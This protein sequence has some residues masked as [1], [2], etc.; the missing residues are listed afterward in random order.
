M[1]CSVP[2]FTSHLVPAGSHPTL[3]ISVPPNLPPSACPL[4]LHLPIPPHIIADRH[5]LQQLH[6]EGRLGA[7]STSALNGTGGGEVSF[8]A[9]G[10][11]DLELP[12]SRAGSGEVLVRLREP[13]AGRDGKGKGKGKEAEEGEVTKWEVPLHLRYLEPVAER[14]D[15]DGARRDLVNVTLEWPSLFWS[16]GPDDCQCCFLAIWD[17]R[18]HPIARL[19]FVATPLPHL[20]Q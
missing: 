17:N 10:E 6:D 12:V 7:P 19:T 5:Q 4:Y 16:C 11:G 9:T 15:A 3:H 18:T 2:Y 13:N 20:S 1:S 14:Y 8:L